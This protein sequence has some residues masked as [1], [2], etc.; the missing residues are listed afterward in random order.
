MQ[1]NLHSVQ[2]AY[3]HVKISTGTYILQSTRARFNQF[4]VSMTCPLCSA[5]DESLH[6]FLLQCEK[7]E[8]TRKPFVDSICSIWNNDMRISGPVVALTVDNLQ[9]LI[10]DPSWLKLWYQDID[11][12]VQTQMYSLARSLCFALHVKRSACLTQ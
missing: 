11:V 4:Q 5:A 2:K 10:M 8:P 9:R 12:T 7:L 6:H 3:V 1:Y